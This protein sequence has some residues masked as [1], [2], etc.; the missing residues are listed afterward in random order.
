MKYRKKP[1]WLKMPSRGAEEAARIRAILLKYSLDTVCRQAKC[2]N[3]GYCYQNGTAT[4]L[5]LGNVCTRS[6]AYCAIGTTA[7]KP[8]PLHPDEPERVAKAAADM[9]LSYVVITS[10]TRDDLPDGGAEHFSRTVKALRVRIEG[11]KIEVLTPDFKGNN[12]SLETVAEADPDVFNHN[13]ETV[14]NLF[15]AVRPDA[16]YDLSL[17]IL[18]RYGKL[19]PSTPLKSGLMLGIGEKDADIRRAI[20]DLRSSGVTMLTLGQ[21]LQPSRRHWPVDRF[22][23]PGEFDNWKEFALSEGFNS[24]A[25]GP[26]VRSSFHAEL[27]YS[28]EAAGSFSL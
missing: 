26:L 7:G 19:S 27:N 16:S 4:F 24:V 1:D 2:P 18:A 6:C 21:Y 9:N 5:I 11:V 23:T 10:V 12:A 25:S 28:T 17:S 22:V 8:D 13:L 3:L 14:E 15:S 20:H